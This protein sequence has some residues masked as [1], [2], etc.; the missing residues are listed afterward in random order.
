MNWDYI[1][2]SWS[3]V[4]VRPAESADLSAHSISVLDVPVVREDG[5]SFWAELFVVG[6]HLK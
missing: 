3:S 2:F 6:N 4:I 5:L 1:W